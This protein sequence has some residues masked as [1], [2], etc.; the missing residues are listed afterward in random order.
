[1][2]KI[3]LA[4]LAALFLF[5][6]IAYAAYVNGYT[7]RDGTYVQGHYRSDPDSSKANNYGP[8]NSSYESSNPSARDNDHD[9]IANMYDNDDDND[10]V[11][12]DNDS[13]QY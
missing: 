3:F 9:G 11:S 2:K 8:N 12:D 5:S 7:R 1:M 13:S 10:G 4:C 6:S